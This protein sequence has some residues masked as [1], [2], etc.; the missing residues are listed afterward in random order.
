MTAFMIGNDIQIS[1]TQ[2]QRALRTDEDLVQGSIKA[3]LCYRN[4]IATCCQQSRFVD[5]IGDVGT[6]HPR[7]GTRN[8]NQVHILCQW[9][10][11]SVNLENGK[12]TV[13]VGP[14]HYHAAV[15]ATRTQE[16]FVQPIR[17]VGGSNDHHGLARIEAIHLNQQLVQSL[18]TLVVAIDTG[19]ALAADGIYLIDEDDAG[20]RFL[21]LVEEIA[22]TTRA[23][24]DQHFDEF[25][26]AH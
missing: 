11:A 17:P 8:R 26:A 6:N 3:V 2:H 5:Q 15:E 21:G 4:Q 23:N 12:A 22:H 13:P 7:R 18:L 25:R 20:S 16:R 19:A 9:Y 14:F 10:A 24:T 1:F